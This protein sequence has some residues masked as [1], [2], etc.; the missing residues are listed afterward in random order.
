[1]QGAPSG[2]QVRRRVQGVSQGWL[3]AWFLF[4]LL[5]CLLCVSF[6]IYPLIRTRTNPRL[7]ITAELLLEL[8][9]R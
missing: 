2:H 1:M 6:D 4:R 7:L 9:G 5:V 8:V 3:V